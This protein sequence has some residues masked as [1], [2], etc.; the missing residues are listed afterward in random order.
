MSFYNFRFILQFRCVLNQII[1]SRTVARTS[2]LPVIARST[3]NVPSAWPT[4]M[5][6]FR[7]GITSERS[8]L[9]ADPRIV[10][11]RL[12]SCSS[13]KRMDRTVPVSSQQR[14][15]PSADHEQETAIDSTL[16]SIGKSRTVFEQVSTRYTE[17]LPVDGI[18]R[19]TR[20]DES[21]EHLRTI[22]RIFKKIFIEKNSIQCCKNGE[23]RGIQI[24]SSESS[25]SWIRRLEL[26][27]LYAMMEL[28]QC[29]MSRATM[30]LFI[31]SFKASIWKLWRLELRMIIVKIILEN[32]VF[33]IEPWS[34]EDSIF[35]QD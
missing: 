1:R 7:E 30:I 3:T 9:P 21:V 16:V 10:R 6:L 28:Y 27:K 23:P 2:Q 26:F 25:K 29:E 31:L 24:L 35:I 34:F 32:L 4:N 18:N 33:K 20:Q 22:H 11:T 13:S 5:G 19:A 14:R 8:F 12:S 15:A 17:S